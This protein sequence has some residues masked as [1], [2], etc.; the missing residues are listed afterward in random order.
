[1]HHACYKNHLEIIKLLVN[2]QDADL[3]AF[4]RAGWLPLH[5]TIEGGDLGCFKFVVQATQ[6]FMAQIEQTR[7]THAI[8]MPEASNQW[9]PLMLALE[10]KSIFIFEYLLE[11]GADVNALDKKRL[12]VLHYALQSRDEIFAVN[13][14]QTER[15][16]A[17]AARVLDEHGQSCYDLAVSKGY[18]QAT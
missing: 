5:S 13:I 18:T 1:M 12:S 8:N 6:R 11:Q 15:C 9:T 10:F 14:L 2:E 3:L 4:N 16:D 7:N 17:A